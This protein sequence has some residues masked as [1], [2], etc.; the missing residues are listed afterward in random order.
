MEKNQIK[1]INVKANSNTKCNLNTYI[2]NN[3][4]NL[5]IINNQKNIKNNI[6]IIIKI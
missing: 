4:I 1:K 5:N 2:I 3:E 6:I